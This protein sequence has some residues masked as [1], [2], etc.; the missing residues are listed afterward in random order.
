MGHSKSSSADP[1]ILRA[2]DEEAAAERG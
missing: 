2:V 1:G